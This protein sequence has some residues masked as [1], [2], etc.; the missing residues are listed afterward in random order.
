MS[1]STLN[2]LLLILYKIGAMADPNINPALVLDDDS[3]PQA[4]QG[5]PSRAAQPSA[6]ITGTFSSSEEITRKRNRDFLDL[7]K[8]PR[9]KKAKAPQPDP[10]VADTGSF[11]NE[12]TPSSIGEASSRQ[13]GGIDSNRA[14]RRLDHLTRWSAFLYASSRGY[15]E[16]IVEVFGN[17][18]PW[19]RDYIIA[20]T[21]ICENSRAYKAATLAAA[22]VSLHNFSPSLTLRKSYATLD[23]SL[24]H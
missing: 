1:F 24:I 22:A 5:T 15:H 17:I 23:L 11:E 3:S 2:V 6:A 16:M 10:N 4:G 7:G 8:R 13:F 19:E 9:I 20:K 12:A 21:K 14:Y 18:E